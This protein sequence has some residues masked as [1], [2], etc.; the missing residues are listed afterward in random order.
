MNY[1]FKE[2][3]TIVFVIN[4]LTG[5]GAERVLVNLLEHLAEPL[6]GCDVHLVLLD[7]EEERQR[8]PGWVKKHVLDCRGSMLQSGIQLIRLLR[9]LSPDLAVSFLNRANCAN[10]AAS[11]LL[12]FPCIL[13]ER[14]HTSSHLPTNLSGQLSRWLIRVTYPRANAV[15]A[16]AQGIKDDLAA[17]FG[18]PADLITVVHNPVDLSDI[19]AR[20]EAAA[21]VSLPEDYVLAAGRLVPNKNFG[22][23]LEAYAA[24]DIDLPLVILGEGPERQALTA[25]VARLGLGE[26]VLMPGWVGN[27]YPTMKAARF[28]VSSSNAEGF[29]NSLVECMSLGCPVVSTDC[30]SGPLDILAGYERPRVT[31]MEMERYG[32]LVPVNDAPALA[33]GIRNMADEATRERYAALSRQRAGEFGVAA[34]VGSYLSIILQALDR[35][36]ELPQ[37]A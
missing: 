25:Q 11:R 15:I 36:A 13:S 33:E 35:K 37:A 27:P 9:R 17:N 31:H 5:G 26:R 24:A 30:N 3:P 10:V 16:V 14:V 8:T 32:I 12:G 22:L 7:I 21:E 2:R 28:F 20:A 34:S 19:E 6:A 29:P 4:S 18:V 1:S 23:L